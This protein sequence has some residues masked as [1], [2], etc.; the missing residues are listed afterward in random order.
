MSCL[1]LVIKYLPQRMNLKPDTEIMDKQSD[2]VLNISEN[3]VSTWN[4]GFSTLCKGDIQ[5]VQSHLR[6]EKIVT[7]AKKNE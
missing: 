1:N 5:S 3:G 7:F 6:I 2:N 4:R